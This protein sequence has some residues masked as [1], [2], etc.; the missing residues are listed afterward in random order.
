MLDLNPSLVFS[1]TTP[2]KATHSA[3]GA[4]HAEVLDRWPR[5][6]R[7]YSNP[8]DQG[9]YRPSSMPPPAIQPT[10]L[11]PFPPLKEAAAF[12]DPAGV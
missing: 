1:N 6:A 5:F 11:N 7:E 10:E 2:L 12:V 3:I 4:V 8:R 9:P